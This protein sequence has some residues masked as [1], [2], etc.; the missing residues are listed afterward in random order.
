MPDNRLERLENRIGYDFKSNGL[1]QRA[2]TH[3]SY[4]REHHNC[5]GDN[6]RL[7]FLGDSILG[8]L[9]CDIL[10]RDYP[11]LAEGDMAKLKS[12]VV[13]EPALASYAMELNLGDYVLLG[14]S[15]LSAGGADRPALLADMFEA[16][17][18]AVYID[19]GLEAATELVCPFIRQRIATAIESGEYRDY[20]TV[21]Q[22]IV[23]E[24]SRITPTYTILSEYGP[25]HDKSFVAAVY[26]GED[27]LGAG[28]GKSKK[29]A[30]QDA[31]R[32]ALEKLG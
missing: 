32:Q 1:L 12:F 18:A 21:L 7:E 30:E 23:Q 24:S 13:S 2:I 6:E 14:R 19:G 9:T 22:E 27:L 8:F 10:Y 5:P 26:A 15:E 29:A 28:K 11:N 16:L 3:S 20:K 25:E 17:T 31:A 4:A